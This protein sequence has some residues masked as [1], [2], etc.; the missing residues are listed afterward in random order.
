MRPADDA[1]GAALCFGCLVER[2]CLIY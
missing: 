2:G 1:N